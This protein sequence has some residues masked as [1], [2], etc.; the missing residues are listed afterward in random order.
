MVELEETLR[1]A[2]DIPLFGDARR[3][4]PHESTQPDEAGAI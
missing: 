3:G 4:A 1:E 2:A